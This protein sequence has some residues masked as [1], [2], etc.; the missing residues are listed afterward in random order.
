MFRARFLQER[1]GRVE[2]ARSTQDQ[3]GTMPLGEVSALF[4]GWKRADSSAETIKRELRIIKPLLCY[5]GKMRAVHS[6]S[7]GLVR[8]YQQDR[9]TQVSPT[10][11]RPIS[12]R[13][14]NYELQLLRGVLSYAG[15]WGGELAAGYKPLREAKSGVGKSAT[16]AQLSKLV[17]T[18]RENDYWAVVMYCA[19]VAAGTGC[20]G[21]EIKNLRLQDIQLSEGK[22][23]IRREIAK[24]R[25]ER[26]PRI[27]ALA[28]WGLRELL[29]RATM[30]GSCEPEHYLLPFCV[31]K[32]RHDAKKTELKWD[33]TRPMVT[34]VKSWRKLVKAAGMDGFR[35]HDLRHTFRTQGAQAGVPLEVM[36]FQLGHMDRETSLD[37]V[38]VQ[39][40]ALHQAQTMIEKEQVEI[41]A[42]ARGR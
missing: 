4:F 37:Y 13:T 21:C 25:I 26:E 42:A 20:R 38:H 2:E 8:Q 30:L 29:L 28:D 39:Q 18:A 1:Q 19:A 27:M 10:M 5:L 24:N 6:I 35:F 14:I 11:K 36:M 7:L 9:R 23:V 3:M 15:C 41:L 33:V 22:I 31:K 40:K 34:W 17:E 32:S 16:N 12:A